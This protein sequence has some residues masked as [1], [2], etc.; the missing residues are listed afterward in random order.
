MA[1]L[2]DEI[3]GRHPESA[4]K[5]FAEEMAYRLLDIRPTITGIFGESKHTPQELR[6]A[7][8]ERG[9]SGDYSPKNVKQAVK[10]VDDKKAKSKK[11]PVKESLDEVEAPIK[12]PS[13]GM[14]LSNPIQIVQ[15]QDA[16]P[17][18][19]KSTGSKSPAR[20]ADVPDPSGTF[21]ARTRRDTEDAVAS[22]APHM[23]K[24]TAD[25][26]TTIPDHAFD[27]N[28]DA[29]AEYY[30]LFSMYKS[31]LFPAMAATSQ[32]SEEVDNV[33][34]NAS[35]SVEGLEKF[36]LGSLYDLHAHHMIEGNRGSAKKVVQH[37]RDKY[38]SDAANDMMA[39]G[40]FRHFQMHPDATQY[41]ELTPAMAKQ[42]ADRLRRMADSPLR[43]AG[44]ALE[45]SAFDPSKKG[46]LD[47]W[48]EHARRSEAH[49][50]GARHEILNRIESHVED[51]YGKE[52]LRKM[53]LHS[54]LSRVLHS[55]GMS[56]KPHVKALLDNMRA[57]ESSAAR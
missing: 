4:R 35:N 25:W 39:H 21:P 41:S 49:G 42:A 10:D 16:E 53:K 3:L 23:T 11:K 18:Q 14:M 15:N 52:G 28:L 27:P 6:S 57:H 20:L 5:A 48:D 12:G 43:E 19:F 26:S 44:P 29:E 55:S 45:E 40:M 17:G 37:V 38:G 46:L 36:G 9:H 33:V 50:S 22:R 8:W 7:M 13:A 24:L 51:H 1:R 30:P 31:L 2:T 47:L 56:E 34:E 32:T 54:D